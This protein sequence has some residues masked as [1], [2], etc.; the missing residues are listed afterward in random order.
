MPKRVFLMV[1]VVMNFV[2][3]PGYFQ[4]ANAGWS[5]VHGDENITYDL[6]AIWGSSATNVYTVGTGGINLFYD[7][8]Q[9]GDWLVMPDISP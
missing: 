5:Q 8:N 2:L 7:G 3:L 9:Q 4:V 1:F 6:W